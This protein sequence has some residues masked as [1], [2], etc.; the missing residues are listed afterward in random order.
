MIYVPWSALVSQVLDELNDEDRSVAV[1]VD[2]FGEMLGALSID[3]ILRRILAPTD[4]D[5][6]LGE[7][8][9]QNMGDDHYRVAGTVSVR[10]LAK[11][12]GI[13]VAGEGIITV[14]GLIQRHNER[15]PRSGDSAPMD[16]FTLT[17]M[18]TQGE[19]LL[20]INVQPTAGL[21]EDPT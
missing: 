14:A 4:D 10:S 17:V 2:E 7:L 1:V 19:N 20:W 5:T 13:E 21:A 6:M 8:A 12:L 9:I 15:L 11:R 3:D 16:R 18:D